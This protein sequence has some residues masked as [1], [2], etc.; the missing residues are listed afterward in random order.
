MR[1]GQIFP[2]QI[3]TGAAVTEAIPKKRAEQPVT[4]SQVVRDLALDLQY[5]LSRKGRAPF[6]MAGVAMFEDL[7]ALRQTLA[8]CLALG[9][10]LQLRRWHTALNDI[11]PAYKFAFVQVRQAL[12][13]VDEVAGILNAPR[14][15]T[16]TDSPGGNAV[17]LKMAHYLGQ[18]ADI[19][20]LSPWLMQFRDTLLTLSER[21]WSG[22]F[23]CYDIIGLPRTNNDHESLYG[24]TKRQLRRQLG[25]S[26]LREP[27]LRRGAWTI[28]QINA[29]SP[30]ELRERLAHVSWED[31]AAER[32]RFEQRQDQFRRRYRWRHHRDDVLRQR[33]TDWAEAISNC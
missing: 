8:Q 22:L 13:W 10:D 29:A 30:A 5:A 21:Y 14:P 20:D 16:E 31:Y 33:L 1:R 4:R 26:E 18:L 9:E 17:A 32:D 12:D 25:V 19:T 28:F 24:Q 2:P 15:T 6:V 27:L 3:V 7:C 23:H 11:L